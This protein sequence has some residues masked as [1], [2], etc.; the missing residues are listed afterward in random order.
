MK[1]TRERFLR[2]WDE[3]PELKHAELINGVVFVGSPVGI[4]HSDWDM[5]AHWWLK[6][7]AHA[8][9][10]LRAGNNATWH[11][12]ASAPQPDAHLCLLQGGTARAVQN[13]FH[14]APELA[15]EISESSASVDFGPKLDLYAR[16]GVQ[17]YLTFEPLFERLTWR[18][19]VAGE[20]QPLKPGPD[21]IYRSKVFPGLW[22]DQAAFWADDGQRLQ[23]V[24]SQGLAD[25]AHAKFVR[26]LARTKRK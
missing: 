4:G 18:C 2:I 1:M 22:L 10:G 11:M 9:P 21:G 8:T 25:P 20:Y 15:V 5:S 13:R 3:L 7:Y 23:E 19:L 12:L 14:G 16:A 24:L 26:R 6:A 17:E